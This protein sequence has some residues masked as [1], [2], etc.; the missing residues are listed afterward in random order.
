MEARG[1][2][3]RGRRGGNMKSVVDGQKSGEVYKEDRYI[4]A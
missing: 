3:R 1:V 2:W 4:H